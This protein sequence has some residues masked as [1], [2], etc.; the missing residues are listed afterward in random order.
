MGRGMVGSAVGAVAGVGLL[1]IGALVGL[2]GCGVVGL[3][4]TE[5]RT[6]Q[7]TDSVQRLDL[8]SDAGAVEVRA[9][10]GPVKVTETVS[11]RGS[12]PDT[13][14]VVQDGTLNLRNQ[15]CSH[16]SVSYLVQL[17][18]GTAVKVQTSAGKIELSGLTG[19]V[20]ADTSA[21]EIGGTDLGSAHTTVHTRAGKIVLAYTAAPSTVDAQTS[22]GA[23]DISLPGGGPY[24]IDASTRAGNTKIGV[25]TDPGASRKITAHSSAGKIVISPAT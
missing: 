3:D 6:Y 1:A 18:A 12:K 20:T 2:G 19:D 14:H 25:P 15:D 8:R 23:V 10:D 16:C 24:A 22:A 11:Y 9:G 4:S 13:S 21:G 17:P 5:V 7:V